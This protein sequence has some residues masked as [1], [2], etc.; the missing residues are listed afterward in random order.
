MNISGFLDTADQD[1]YRK[2]RNYFIN[3]TDC[4]QEHVPLSVRLDTMRS[5]HRGVGTVGRMPLPLA[6]MGEYADAYMFKRWTCKCT[7]HVHVHA[8]M[9]M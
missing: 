2:Q 8:F 7:G 3:C 4:I 1:P 9:C 5:P 6:G